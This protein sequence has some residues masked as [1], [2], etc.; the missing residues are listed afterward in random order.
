MNPHQSGRTSNENTQDSTQNRS[1]PEKY[2]IVSN[3]QLSEFS[4]EIIRE[5][6]RDSQMRTVYQVCAVVNRFCKVN[7]KKK[8]TPKQIGK[9]LRRVRKA[10]QR[11]YVSE[12][13]IPTHKTYHTVTTYLPPNDSLTHKNIGTITISLTRNTGR[14]S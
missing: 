12:S 8:Y 13:C 6:T 3:Q 1:E 11:K 2:K 14:C 9:Y 7:G 10:K 4:K 5:C